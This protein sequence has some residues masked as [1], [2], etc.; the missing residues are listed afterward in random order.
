MSKRNA[1]LVVIFFILVVVLFVFLFIRK[2][3]QATPLV[4]EYPSLTPEQQIS[5]ISQLN[6]INKRDPVSVQEK[7]KIIKELSANASGGKQLTDA[8]K[9]A[10]IKALNK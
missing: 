3:K 9:E 2:N 8:E 6:A 5:T 4:N 10:I 1:I 7:N